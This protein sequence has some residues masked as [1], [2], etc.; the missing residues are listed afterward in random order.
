MLIR[1][2]EILEPGA[3]VSPTRGDVRIADGRITAID[4]GLPDRGSE[5]VIDA[6]GGALL[7]GLHDHHLHLFALAAA[8]GS[9]RCGPPEV[10]EEAMLGAAL[11]RT[12]DRHLADGEGDA[13][14]RGVGY[15]ESVAGELDAPRLDALERRVPIR[16]QHRT[17]ACWIVNGAGLA[18]LGLGG[19]LAPEVPAGVERDAG[20]RATGRLFRMDAWL[21]ERLGAPAAPPRLDAV[22]ERLARFGV[23]GVTD[24]SPGNGPSELAA[25]GA[26]HARGALPQQVWLMGGRSLP[27]P[28]GAG[29]FRSAWKVILDEARLPELA[30]LEAGIAEAHADGRRVAVHCV[31]RTE[32]VFAIAAFRAAGSL[33]G[34]RIE[35]AAVAPPELLEPVAALGLCVVTQPGFVRE[36]G[37]AYL[38]DV[39]PRDRPWLYRGRGLLAAGIPLGGGTDAP[40][41]DPDPWL[42]MQA[43]V[44]RRTT[45]GAVLAADEALSPDRALALFTTP[46]GDPGG[47]PRRVAV[48]EPADL[49]LLDRP[50]R[51]AR[52]VLSSE[53]V[54][55]NVSGGRLV[56]SRTRGGRPA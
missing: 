19:L 16:I 20:G 47:A 30:V 8:A 45:G 22:G 5:P 25:I 1:N 50:W 54:V 29:V 48:R 2:A 28:C 37:D 3:A 35:H 26:A 23:C 34:D 24:A 32:L 13:W 9:L 14:I 36:R 56:W 31:T 51:Q 39:A 42:A 21:R 41:G 40:F 53:L 10:A 33:P 49:C 46:A 4:V 52:D 55:A 38:R 44:D 12:A 11:R 18:R 27:E 17:G 43:A 7:P 6:A 15:H